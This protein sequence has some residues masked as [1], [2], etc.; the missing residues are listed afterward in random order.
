MKKLLAGI[1]AF[2]A[3]CTAGAVYLERTYL[4]TLKKKFESGVTDE[5]IAWIN[6]VPH[7]DVYM[8]TRDGYCMHGLVFDNGSRN[9]VIAVHGY[10]SESRGMVRYAKRF[11]EEG[12]SVFMPDMR[13][14]GLSEGTRTSM[15]HFEKYD[16]I[17]W[18]RK[19]NAEYTPDSITLFGVSMGA[20]TVMLTAGETLPEN[21]KAVVEDC[22]YSSVREQFEHSMHDIYHLPPYPVLWITDIITRLNAGWSF[23]KDADCM[24]AVSRSKLP[25]CFIH[26]TEDTFV[27]FR[28]QRKLYEACRHPDKEILAVKGAKHTE[29]CVIEPEVYWNTVL[30]FIRKN[31]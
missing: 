21:V 26:G 3:V 19:L 10:D 7:K 1:A 23:L 16:V 25:M 2:I 24:K 18:I 20:A 17:D 28:M 8:V 11:L 14:M 12:F 31:I 22:G 15:G 13:G 6:S 29:A 4:R 27:P 5:N 9:W 30:G